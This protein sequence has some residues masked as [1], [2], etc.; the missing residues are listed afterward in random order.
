MRRASP[1]A[2][3]AR[4]LGEARLT[5]AT[6]LATSDSDAEFYDYDEARL[7]LSY[8]PGTPILG[9]VISFEAEVTAADFD[10]W[11]FLLGAPADDLTRRDVTFRAGIDAVLPALGRYGFAPVL[12]LEATDRNSTAE[13]YEFE[14][15]GI[16]IG[17]R[18]VF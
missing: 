7:G 12:S 8:A 16:G 13:I 10:D 4:G 9:A 2:E 17:I 3:I 11:P 18:S 6:G 1:G 14:Q 15:I 5:V